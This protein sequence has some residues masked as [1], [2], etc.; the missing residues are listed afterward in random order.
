[1]KISSRT[2]L[3]VALMAALPA[4]SAMACTVSN[5]NGTN[6]ATTAA[7]AKGP[8]DGVA[9]YSGECALTVGSGKFVVDNSPGAEAV[10]RSR[11]YVLTR[12]VTGAV[13]IFKATASDNGAGA[14]AVE[15][16]FD[17]TSFAFSQNGAA[18]GSVTG[19]QA[20]KWY[21]I[22]TAYKA[23]NAFTASVWGAG[24]STEVGSV[25]G[26]AGAAT[27]GSAVMGI[28]NGTAATAFNFDA[29]ES[30]RS[31]AT[32]IG[33]LCRGDANGSSTITSAD[34]ASITA[35][36][37][38]AY[39]TGQPDCNEDGR[40]NSADRACITSLITIGASCS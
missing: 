38:G 28:S 23:G 16:T 8:A 31:E 27:V 30:T 17:G 26:T 9:R 25:S 4:T 32:A 3:A 33:R 37:N 22:E 29:F 34:R 18:A 1:M 5:W 20:D 13:T 14:A 2:I 39:A 15:I 40:V 19:I 11:F 36:I 12:P 6:T 24:G 35:E 10:Y 7:N 21:S